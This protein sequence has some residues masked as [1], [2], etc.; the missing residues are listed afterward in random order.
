MGLG[1]IIRPQ[2]FMI[3]HE[4]TMLYC[5]NCENRY[6]SRTNRRKYEWNNIG[7]TTTG[8]IFYAECSCGK[9]YCPN[10]GLN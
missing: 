5:L 9:I 8:Y 3:S 1:N 4:N 7:E 2:N 10:E 6:S